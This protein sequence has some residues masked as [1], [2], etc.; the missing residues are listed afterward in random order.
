MPLGVFLTVAPLYCS[1]IAPTATRGAITA[2]VSFCISLG[3]LLAYGV[4]RETQTIMGPNSYRIM[5]AVQWGFSVILLL[6]L[7]FLPESP[8]RLLAR[9]K[10]DSAKNSIRRLYPVDEEGVQAQI[11][12]IQATI[13]GDSE[14][15]AHAG[16][17]K[18]C[19][20]GT[21]LLRT[22]SAMGIF[23]TQH[24]SGVAWI[25]GYMG[26]FMQLGGLEGTTVFNLTVV[27][28]GI[29]GLGNLAGLI[30]LQIFGRRPTITNGTYRHIQR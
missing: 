24:W 21:N 29:M 5:F 8:I 18:D 25:I 12:A 17:Y 11:D 14:A 6:L 15:A 10:V 13:A 20:T 16:S 22:L 3:Q 28:A 4:M 1:E 26:Y 2:G 7:P 23:F 27:I 19:F 9:G 30:M